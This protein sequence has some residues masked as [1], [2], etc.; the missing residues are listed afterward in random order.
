MRQAAPR[1]IE[2]ATGAQ[3]ERRELQHMLEAIAPG[4]VVTLT[5]IDWL[6]CSTFDL[7][8]IVKGI[9]DSGGQFR[10]LVKPWADGSTSTER[11]MLADRPGM[12]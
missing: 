12:A 4:E 8:F 2:K 6:A 3:V 10:S 5:R 11:L 7:L 9:T 1:Y